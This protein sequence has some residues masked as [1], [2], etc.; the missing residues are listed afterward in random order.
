MSTQYD[1]TNTGTI[2]KNA[3]KEKESQPDIKG[4]LNVDGREFW[5]SGWRKERKDGTGSFY[6][7]QVTPKDEQTEKAAS[8]GKQ[9]L[10]ALDDDIPF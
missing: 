6:S 8:A 5:V 3:R 1:N 10:A 4:Q 9:T 2:S 7:L